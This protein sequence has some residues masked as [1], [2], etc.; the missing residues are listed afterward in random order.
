[1]RLKD[2]ATIRSTG[3]AGWV[4]YLARD[5]CV[6]R[7][8]V[9]EEEVR[10]AVSYLPPSCAAWATY[11]PDDA[12]QL[13]FIRRSSLYDLLGSS[14]SY[15]GSRS[16]SPCSTDADDSSSAPQCS[17]A[18]VRDT[19]VTQRVTSPPLLLEME[20]ALHH[21][22]GTILAS[23][24]QPSKD[25]GGHSNESS[26]RGEQVNCSAKELPWHPATVDALHRLA[27]TEGIQRR[28]ILQEEDGIWLAD[29]A[30]TER[31]ER[32]VWAVGT[33]P[34]ENVLR[35]WIAK[36]RA[37]GLV[38]QLQRVRLEERETAA[39]LSIIES[40]R[41][42]TMRQSL[43]E[44]ALLQQEEY[45]RRQM[46]LLYVVEAH[47]TGLVLLRLEEQVRRYVLFF[48]H[49]MSPQRFG[50]KTSA[51]TLGRSLLFAEE[52]SRRQTVAFEE[53]ERNAIPY[54]ME[55]VYLD[56][57][58][59]VKGRQQLEQSEAADRRRLVQMIGALEAHYSAREVEI[60]EAIDRKWLL[61]AK[62]VPSFDVAVSD[63]A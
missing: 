51:V 46:E 60:V 23:E 20:A 26:H 44:A 40:S 8:A 42:L 31:Y 28:A 11:A 54:T 18:E 29:V 57:L 61:S 7:E 55:L 56:D 35:H 16:V 32:R 50:L 52:T 53:L 48:G 39:R 1:M 22:S 14:S 10:A 41:T 24:T 47:R 34:L 30:V 13:T 15:S 3:A 21:G 63:A 2:H 33:L 49:P 59:E 38:H 62:E 25:D 5:E 36:Y 17:A 4:A 43:L 37:R 27:I 12:G 9:V 19:L 6:A 45:Y 58:T